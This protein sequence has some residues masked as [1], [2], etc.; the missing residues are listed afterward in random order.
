MY[1]PPV[2]AM[3]SHR[4]VS[5]EAAQLQAEFVKLSEQY[6]RFTELL[7]ASPLDGGAF[8]SNPSSPSAVPIKAYRAEGPR[9]SPRNGPQGTLFADWPRCRLPDQTSELSRLRDRCNSLAARHAMDQQEPPSWQ[10]M[11]DSTIAALCQH[12]SEAH[13]VP[14]GRLVTQT[15]EKLSPSSLVSSLGL[16]DGDVLHA[17]VRKTR[18]A[19]SPHQ[20]FLAQIKTDGNVSILRHDGY[21]NP[22]ESKYLLAMLTDVEEIVASKHSF[23]ARRADGSVVT[24]G[25]ETRTDINQ[26]KQLAASIHAFAAV[27]N[28]GLVET[29]GLAE[30][31][32]DSEHL[33][34]RLCDVKEVVASTYAFAALRVDGTVLSWG[35]CTCGGD[36]SE[37]DEQLTD[38]QQIAATGRAF[39]AIRG[40]GSV[41]TWGHKAAGADS[42]PVRAELQDVCRIAASRNAFAAITAAGHVIT[43]GQASSGGSMSDVEAQLSDVREIVGSDGAFAALAGDG[44]VVTW[45]DSRYGGDI[46]AVREQLADV[47]HLCAS[48][49]AFA[50]L[51]ADGSV[52][53]WGHA[54]AG[55]DHS[56]VSEQLYDIVDVAA[57]KNGFAAL[58]QDDEVITW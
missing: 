49:F 18:L 17:L 6:R 36:S 47:Q 34:S 14:V 41:V 31:G 26:V 45:G 50:A 53:S 21:G 15:G 37:V 44:H 32:G 2:L 54:S 42:A 57:T 13:S 24:W 40:D 12:A 33:R 35:E 30:Y 19:R 52:V 16:E 11:Q 27:R 46:R 28:D 58:R 22:W 43:W 5:P 48:R 38:V 9:V 39:A 25:S 55:G 23:A 4:A 20:D 1:Q 3:D 51:R 7:P 10:L 29:W 56:S 8:S